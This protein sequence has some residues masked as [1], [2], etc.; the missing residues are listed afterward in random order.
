MNTAGSSIYV[1]DL[2]YIT[3]DSLPRPIL[4]EAPVK[5]LLT[6]FNKQHVIYQGNVYMNNNGE[7][8]QITNNAQ[9]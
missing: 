3:V 2:D 6:S 7:W 9:Q 4:H 8:L 1:K 5:G